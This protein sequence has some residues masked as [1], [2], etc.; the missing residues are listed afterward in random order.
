MCGVEFRFLN[1]WGDVEQRFTS[2]MVEAS[3]AQAEKR[4]QIFAQVTADETNR[5]KVNKTAKQ[6]QYEKRIAMRHNKQTFLD[7]NY[8]PSSDSKAKT[9]QLELDAKRKAVQTTLKK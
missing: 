3:R 4:E 6:L 2:R 1:A 5:L 7:R 8:K 9:A